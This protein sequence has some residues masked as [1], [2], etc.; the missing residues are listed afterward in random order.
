MVATRLRATHDFDFELPPRI[1]S[2]RG[3][4]RES[5]ASHGS[6][7]DLRGLVMRIAVF[8]LGYV[9]CVTG[10][11]LA[12]LGHEVRGVDVS[13]VKVRM[14][15]QG[16]S[17]V[18]EKGL[19]GLVRQAVRAG[20]LRA[21]LQPAE[22]IEGADISLISVGTPAR[23]N[24][25]ANLDFVMRAAA[26]IGGALRSTT[27]FHT[28]VLRS[29]VPPGTTQN[30]LI[31]LLERRS[32]KR[33]G[34]DFGVCFHP[35]FMREGSSLHDFFHPPRNVIGVYD[36]RSAARLLR[37]YEPIKSPLFV[38][39]LK[40]AEML[41]Y[42][43]NAFHALKVCFANEVG[44]L[45]KSFGIDSHEVMRIFIE[46]RKLNISPLYLKPGFAFGG[47]CL[48][49]DLRALS[50][51]G[52]TAGLKIPLI[53]SVLKSNYFH[54]RRAA[55]LVL[56]SGKK[57]R[58]GVLGLVFKSGTDDLRES[59]ACSL[60]KHLLRAKRKVAVYDPRVR[61]DRLLGANRAFFERQ[62]PELPQ[63]LAG[64]LRQVLAASEVIVLAGVH[65]EFEKGVQNLNRRQVLVDLVRLPPHA[66]PARRRLS[67]LC[68]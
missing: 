8:G 66:I 15:N 26:E 59:P 2:R 13:P 9:G 64:S 52:R 4:G 3:E 43:D 42:A 57:K 24:G 61:L 23:R 32:R 55:E 10:A 47:P 14:I 1:Y 17:P 18:V 54:V 62:L 7:L 25:Q 37:L 16:H 36:S 38:T 67:G 45:C 30:A 41:K 58:V 5:E 27:R 11:C 48:T 50:S 49:K 65:P 53:N 68:W 31:P 19:E 63:L 29:T 20:R 46:D 28:V 35:E 51:I 34:R 12:R 6:L 22:A 40:V 44:A 21:S 60:V 39:S 33:A 56:A